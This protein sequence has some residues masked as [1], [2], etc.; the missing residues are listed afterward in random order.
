MEENDL[1]EIDFVI[2]LYELSVNKNI[3]YVKNEILELTNYIRSFQN[4]CRRIIVKCIIETCYLSDEQIKELTFWCCHVGVDF[5]KTSTG[6]GTRGASEHDIKIIKEKISR[7]VEIKASGGINTFEQAVIFFLL[8][9]SRIGTSSSVEIINGV[10]SSKKKAVAKMIDHTN[11]NVN[12][13]EKDIERSAKEAIKFGFKTICV[14]PE[15]L[16]TAYNTTKNSDVRVC[17]AVGFDK[18]V[19]KDSGIKVNSILGSRLGFERYNQSIEEKKVVMDKLF[20]I[21]VIG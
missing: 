11:L 8:G 10:E 13:S 2:N 12:A 16:E 21:V 15:H 14:R 4:D 7:E 6:Y 5:V 19:E 3:E 9:A 17:V 20:H 1:I 18:L